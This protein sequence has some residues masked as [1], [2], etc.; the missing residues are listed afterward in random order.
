MRVHQPWNSR[1][2][3]AAA[4]FI[5]GL[6]AESSSA[7]IANGQ[8]AGR[9]ISP[10][11]D[12][13]ATTL[14]LPQAAKFLD[15]MAVSWTRERKCGSCHSHFP[16]L[17]ARPVL[18]KQ[19]SPALDE[20]RAFF[21]QRVAHWDDDQSAAKPRADGEVIATATA[22]ALS[23][24]ATGNPLHPLTRAALDR[25]WSVQKPDGGFEWI[26]CAWPPLEH[27]DYYGA[28]VVALGVGHAPGAYSQTPAAQSGLGH[29]RA[30]LAKNPAPDLHHRTVL[31]W[32]AT[33]ID[34]L[35]SAAQKDATIQQLR[36]LQHSDGG[37]SLP[38]LGSW[39]RR[40]GTP[41]DP[42]APS[43]GY[44]TG[45]VVYV[46]RQTGVPTTDPALERGA[47]WLRTHQR[48]SGRWFTRSLNTDSKN[49]I[50]R[51]GTAYCVLALA[52]CDSSRHAGDSARK[53]GPESKPA[54]RSNH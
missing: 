41:N 24:A 14:S 46:L 40:D 53:D 17:F 2:L 34:G 23:D 43:D 16:Y 4:F 33:Q 35:M 25:I 51:I 20:V 29:L 31:L 10:P 27:D 54:D 30:Y 8:R 6:M 44:A 9:A 49:Y 45:L 11:D 7:Q 36:G 13:V 12:P 18:G 47:E 21:E 48:T 15:E 19:P 22:L 42:N 39:K 37:W 5:A 1:K 38:S 28:L 50:S 26:K 3:I 32:A 52:A